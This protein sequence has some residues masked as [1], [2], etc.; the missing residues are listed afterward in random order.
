MN[1]IRLKFQELINRKQIVMFDVY[2]SKN[3]DFYSQSQK[4]LATFSDLLTEVQSL[5][6][7][8]SILTCKSLH[9]PVM[10]ELIVIDNTFVKDFIK[11]FCER[12][13]LFRSDTLHIQKQLKLIVSNIETLPARNLL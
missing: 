4:N 12:V 1:E 7:R 13:H 5:C 10:T 3:L 11:S 2:L 8:L 9:S 6:H